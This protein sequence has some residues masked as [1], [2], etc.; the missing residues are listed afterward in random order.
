M[1][2]AARLDQPRGARIE[3]AAAEHLSSLA[4]LLKRVDLES[5]GEVIELLRGVRQAGAT[6]FVAGNGGSA[7]TAS[8]WV[9]DLCKATRSEGSP[10]IRAVCLSD[11]M[12]LLTAL[13]NDEG[14]ERV[15][16]AQLESLGRKGDMLVLISASGNSPNL[17]SAVGVARELGATTVGL[18]GFDGGALLDLVDAHVLLSTA[19]GD[20]EL[21][22]DGHAALCHAMTVGL[23]SDLRR[24][25]ESA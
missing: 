19:L 8:H 10:L 15:F 11:N 24:G 18:L 20:Y 23:K 13:A 17:V 4:T 22:E 2:T 14:Y 21:V 7:A 25:R 3:F 6:V 12:S 16:S 5:L 9:N 1:D